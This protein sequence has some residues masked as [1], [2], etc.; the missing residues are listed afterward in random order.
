MLT[1]LSILLFIAILLIL[2]GCVIAILTL[3]HQRKVQAHEGHTVR[4]GR[5]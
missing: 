5:F 4:D 1:L 3:Y 2:A